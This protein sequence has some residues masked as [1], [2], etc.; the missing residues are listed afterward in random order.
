[1]GGNG[2]QPNWHNIGVLAAGGGL[3]KKAFNREGRQGYA[4][5]AKKNPALPAGSRRASARALRVELFTCPCEIARWKSSAVVR[6]QWSLVFLSPTSDARRLASAWVSASGVSPALRPHHLHQRLVAPRIG[7]RAQLV[8]PGGTPVI[9]GEPLLIRKGLV[10]QLDE[11][12]LALLDGPLRQARPQ[13]SRRT[14]RSSKRRARQSSASGHVFRGSGRDCHAI[15]GAFCALSGTSERGSICS[16]GPVDID[17]A[18]T[19]APFIPPSRTSVACAELHRCH[20]DHYHRLLH[21]RRLTEVPQ[22]SRLRRPEIRTDSHLR[23]RQFPLPIPMEVAGTT[24][25]PPPPSDP[26]RLPAPFAAFPVPPPPPER[27]GG[28]GTTS[29]PPADNDPPPPRTPVPLPE[30]APDS[31]GG[32]G[33]TA[34]PLPESPFPNPTAR[35]RSTAPALHRRRWRHDFISSGGQRRDAATTIAP[36]LRRGWRR[37]NLRAASRQRTHTRG[38]ASCSAAFSLQARRRRNDFRRTAREPRTQRRNQSTASSALHRWRRRNHGRAHSVCSKPRVHCRRRFLLP[39]SREEAARLQLPA[40]RA[41]PLCPNVQS[42]EAEA[43]PRRRVSRPRGPAPRNPCDANDGGGATTDALP[44]PRLPGIRDVPCNEGGGATTFGAPG[45]R[46]VWSLATPRA[47]TG[48]ATIPACSD[49]TSP[50][51]RPV[52]SGGGATAE[53]SPF[54]GA[55][56]R[57][58]ADSGT[59]G[60]VGSAA[61]F[62]ARGPSASFRSGGTTSFGVPRF[63]AA[64]GMAFARVC[65][66]RASSL[67]VVLRADRSLPRRCCRPSTPSSRWTPTSGRPGSRAASAAMPIPG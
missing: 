15:D 48:G 1:M 42:K 8:D 29:T 61:K 38:S 53:F 54:S 39:A 50:L 13:T 26:N 34:A 51:V 32:G 31:D 2:G 67:R 14:N 35:A 64:T 23:R 58:V 24:A 11:F 41:H 45:P 56:L 18:S 62:G 17:P 36:A 20:P 4:K 63:S 9:F 6:K 10:Y 33:T 47:S 65:R 7:D 55:L 12:L 46:S 5:D 25:P 66:S 37:H 22:H 40:P 49:P 52:T 57:A 30:P 21:S 16:S 19:G 59:D 3:N 44:A 27:D 28:G 43:R 60:I